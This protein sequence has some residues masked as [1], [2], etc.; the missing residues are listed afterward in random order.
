MI[1]RSIGAV[2]HGIIDYALAIL[3]ITGPS[4]A[5]FAGT[6][7]TWAYLFGGLLLAMAI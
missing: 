6:K 2:S 5:G 4:F 3:L 1:H 7:A